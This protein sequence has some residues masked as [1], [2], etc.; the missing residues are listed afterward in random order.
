[1]KGLECVTDFTSVVVCDDDW[2]PNHV[3]HVS[4]NHKITNIIGVEDAPNIVGYLRIRTK[5]GH[6]LVVAGDW[7]QTK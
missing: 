6:Y 3:N 1:M 7:G 4:R 2:T 5:L